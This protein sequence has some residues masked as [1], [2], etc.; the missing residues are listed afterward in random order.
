MNE[1]HVFVAVVSGQA[2]GGV[3]T[4]IIDII[5]LTFA[6]D[7]R[8]SAFVFF[9]IG[10]GLLVLSLF[11]YICISRSVFF[12]Y[13]TAEEYVVIKT[14]HGRLQ[15]TNTV[16]EPVFKE[17]INKMWLYGFTEWLVIIQNQAN[18]HENQ[19]S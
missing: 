11:A 10:N 7:P 15:R 16:S 9:M 19:L 5:T 6:N 18:T 13:Y 12:K 17:V 4:A 2:L 3:F 8:S 14:P 1:K